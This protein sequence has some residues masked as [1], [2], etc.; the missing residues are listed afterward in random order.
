[1]A[2]PKLS[3]RPVRVREH[4]EA[5]GVDVSR[6]V[7]YRLESSD[8]QRWPVRKT[9]QEARRDRNEPPPQGR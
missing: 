4:S 8:G 3:V 6:V 2:Q 5:F 9:V 1:M 7:G